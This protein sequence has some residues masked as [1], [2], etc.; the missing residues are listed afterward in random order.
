MEENII[1]SIS[2]DLKISE[3]QTMAVLAMLEEG[4]TIP[5]IA[6]YRKEATGGLEEVTINEIQKVYQYECDLKARK[7]AVIRLIDEK[8]MLT[9]ELKNQILAAKKLI[10]VEDLY[11]PFKEK[12]KTKATEAVK[13]GLQGLADYIMAQK[14]D[15]D[16]KKEAEKYLNDMVPTVND[17]VMN[18]LYIIAETISDN[19][20]IRKW[21]RNFVFTTGSLISKIKKNAEK[22]DEKKVYENYYEYKEKLTSIKSH[23]LLAMNRGEDEKVLTLSFSYEDEP[24]LA[25]IEKVYLH[26][27][28]PTIV[29]LYKMCIKDSFNRLIAPSIEREIYSSMFEDAC[30]TAINIF[31]K[32]AKQLLLQAPIKNKMVLGVDPGYRTGCKLAVVDA[33]GKFIAKY[34]MFPHNSQKE[35][36]EALLLV[37][38]VCHAFDIDIIAIGNGTASR[39]TEKLILEAIGQIDKKIQYAIVSEA[40]ASVYS[41]S[42]EARKEF[43]DFHVE[44]RSAVSIARRLID[45]L[46]E[47]VKIDP[48][49]IGVGQYQHD[50]NQKKL[51]EELTFVV[52]SAVNTV[53]VDLNTA[54]GSLLRYVSGLTNAVADNIVKYRDAHGI[55]T[56]REEL[57]K[58]SRLNEKVYQQAA[59]F[60]RVKEGSNPLDATGIHPES[61]EIAKTIMHDFKIS[62]EELGTSI[63]GLKL[64]NIDL[65]KYVKLLNTDKYTLEDVIKYLKTPSL[66]PRDDYDKPLLKSEQ[67]R[68]EDLQSGDELEGTVRN[69]IDFGAFVDIGIADKEG[70]KIDGLVHIS[71]I[72]KKYIKHPIDVLHIGQIVKVWVLSVDHVKRRIQLTM[73]DPN[74][75]K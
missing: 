28:N 23:R 75:D 55:F 64:K 46:A 17:A 8:G 72:T 51:D 37:K 29:A 68:F 57:L 56:T 6:R 13:M 11:R 7:E 39:E 34:K 38:K 70:H 26:C 25:H 74:P 66:D 42:E 31:G 52:T 60:L 41:A 24:I 61:Y 5:F 30:G 67:V 50:V 35:W 27:K 59:G 58:V 44:E 48:K 69:I 15:S 21:I 49:S 53:G 33:T 19:A 2:A 36:S 65:N 3:K 9:E 18:A 54:S 40:G 47:L 10:D 14:E 32:N 43:P 22:L 45:P 12:K 20:D 1:K 62:Y 4:N 71:K 73:I 16:V 63:V